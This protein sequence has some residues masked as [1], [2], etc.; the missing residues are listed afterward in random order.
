MSDKI[1]PASL[2]P[3][4][5][6]GYG[7]TRGSNIWRSDVQGGLPRQGRDTYYEAVPISVV[8]VVGALGR[9][10]FWSFYASISGGADSFQMTH[11][12]GN[13]LEPHNV[14]IT[15]NVTETTQDGINWVISFTATAER[16]SVQDSTDFSEALWPMYG[17]YGDGISDFIDWYAQYCTT[18]MFIFSDYGSNGVA[19]NGTTSD[20]LHQGYMIDDTR[21]GFSDLVTFSRLS[22][23]SYIDTD[24]DL[25]TAAA[26]EPRF[27]SGGL[28]VEGQSTNMVV[29]SEILPSDLQAGSYTVT[30][31][32]VQGYNLHSCVYNSGDD[33]IVVFTLAT[34][35]AADG[36]GSFVFNS[37]TIIG[38]WSCYFNGTDDYVGFWPKNSSA[39]EYED[40]GKGL[41]RASRKLKGTTLNTIHLRCGK[42]PG[43]RIDIGC[44][45]IEALPYATSYIPTNG[46]AATRAADSAAVDM[47]PHT[48][49]TI[50]VQFLSDSVAIER[51]VYTA[52]VV[53]LKRLVT[54]AISVT[55]DAVTVTS[56][57]VPSGSVK[58][59]ISYDGSTLKL[60][61]NGVVYSSASALPSVGESISLGNTTFANVWQRSEAFDDARLVEVT[62]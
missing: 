6:R 60:A 59:A 31:S 62:K 26:N 42:V 17:E 43:S 9:Q 7:Q 50:F 58:A 37:A 52:G 55:A 10:A 13:G 27:E 8:L 16:T 38:N 39:F 14:L 53:T 45:Q 21:K 4:V 34:L 12:T 1:F 48:V 30:T 40:L 61:V 32:V 51:V 54:G 20:F 25:K 5:S 2:K 46:A 19:T 18:P 56:A 3:I 23:G 35:Q 24:G 22:S 28:L 11:D 33:A 47:Q 57:V 44:Y 41:I 49:G 29:Q 15:S 36:T